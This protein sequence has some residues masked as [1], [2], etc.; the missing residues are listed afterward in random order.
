MCPDNTGTGLKDRIAPAT[1]CLRLALRQIS[2]SAVGLG[3]TADVLPGG[4]HDMQPGRLLALHAPRQG[5]RGGVQSTAP[6][7]QALTGP[8]CTNAAW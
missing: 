8:A 7:C 2:R 6:D 3:T 5:M 1:P 4:V